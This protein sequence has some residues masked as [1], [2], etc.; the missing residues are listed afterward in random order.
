MLCKLNL[1]HFALF[2]VVPMFL[3]SGCKRVSDGSLS[4]VDDNGGYASD[5]SRIE[6]INDDVISIADAAGLVFNATYLSSCATVGTD[7]Q[8]VGNHTLIIRF[9]NSGKYG[10]T[11]PDDDCV[12]IDGRKR[13]GSIIVSY[14]GHYFDSGTVHTITYDHYFI[15]D[16]QLT[17]SVRTIIAD[18]TVTG[19]W[20]YSVSVN[21]SLSM[22]TDPS[23]NQFI[24]WNGSFDRK[25]ISGEATPTR[26]DDGYLVSGSATLTRSNGHQFTFNISSPL[27]VMTGCDYIESGI[28][29]VT[30]VAGSRILNYGTGGCDDKAQVSVGGTTVYDFS[31]VK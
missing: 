1:R 9:G 26:S 20:H 13:R 6:W 17:G 11:T 19:N 16:N 28:V 21:D 30:G 29:T 18:T 7:T 24:V 12:G 4:D 25:W 22:N 15:N 8:S 31:L 27:Q 5:A 2:V 23:G 10:L 14:S 3:F